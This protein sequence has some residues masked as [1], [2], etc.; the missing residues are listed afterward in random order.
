M[1]KGPAPLDI[2]NGLFSTVATRRFW[3]NFRPITHL[4]TQ[5]DLLTCSR[6]TS[7]PLDTQGR[8]SGW[9]ALCGVYSKRAP[10]RVGKFRDLNGLAQDSRAGDSFERCHIGIAAGEHDWQARLETPGSLG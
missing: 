7:C 2:K 3:I 10:D 5:E 1:A 8:Q 6:Y 9:L 4:Q